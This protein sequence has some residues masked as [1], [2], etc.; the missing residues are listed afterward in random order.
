MIEVTTGIDLVEVNRLRTIKAAIKERFLSRVYTPGELED[1]N[2][3]ETSLAGRFAAKEAAAKALGCGIGSIHWQD[4]EIRLDKSGKP[5]LNL[6]G[7]ALEIAHEQ[8]WISWS[9][10]ISH[11]SNYAIACVTALIDRD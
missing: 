8:A 3:R 7:R 6:Y 1:C 11:S 5:V 4:V 9:V 10:S 2:A